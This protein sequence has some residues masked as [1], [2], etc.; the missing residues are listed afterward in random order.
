[1]RAGHAGRAGRA[2]ELREGDVWQAKA[3]EPDRCLDGRPGEAVSEVSYEA[4]SAG[5]AL[6]WRGA[7]KNAPGE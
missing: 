1:M 2:G 5:S 3:A 4:G 7:G 6:F